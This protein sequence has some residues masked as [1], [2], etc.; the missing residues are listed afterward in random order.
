MKNPNFFIVGAAKSGTTSLYHYLKKHPQVYLSP[1]KEPNYF[2]KDIKTENFSKTYKKNTIFLKDK[3]FKQKTPEEIQL[4]FIRNAKHYASLF[5]NVTHEKAIG[6]CSTSYLYSSVAAKEIYQYNPEA[7]IIVILRNPYYRTFSHYLMAVRYG[8]TSLKFRDAII[9]D[10]EKKEKG[11]GIS[12]LF[13]ELSLYYE[14]LK[15][16]YDA[17]PS[18]QV[19]VLFFEELQV[20]PV[21]LI[22]KCCRFLEIDPFDDISNEKH[23]TAALPRNRH[24]N[25]IITATGIKRAFISIGGEG[26][27]NKMKTLFYKKPTNHPKLATEDKDFLKPIFWENIQNTAQLLK[28]DLEKWLRD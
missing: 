23:N 10:M 21:G 12:E 16:Y 11:W 18:K 26:V 4:S 22:K 9:K 7:K 15:R 8:F 2:S 14:Q 28:A 1:V 19:L 3:Y 17:F 6:E 25:R 20:N 24:I 5:K 13:I 27:K